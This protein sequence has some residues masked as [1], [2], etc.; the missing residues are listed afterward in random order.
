MESS[1]VIL[2]TKEFN[3]SRVYKLTAYLEEGTLS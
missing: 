1:L 3:R 2:K